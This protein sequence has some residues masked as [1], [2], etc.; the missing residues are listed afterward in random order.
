TPAGS[1]VLAAVVVGGIARR[2]RLHRR[3]LHHVGGLLRAPDLLARP[4]EGG[5]DVRPASTAHAEAAGEI[6]K[7]LRLAHQPRAL[8]LLADRA[9]PGRSAVSE[10][11]AQRQ[12]AHREVAQ[13]RK[14]QRARPDERPRPLLFADVH[15][16]L[17]DAMTM[18]L[19]HVPWLLRK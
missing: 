8:E 11:A 19:I 14:Q 1:V 3:L 9:V 12:P 15:G 4:A 17:S 13:A 2:K 5:V 10:I 6:R 16:M 18:R 7:A